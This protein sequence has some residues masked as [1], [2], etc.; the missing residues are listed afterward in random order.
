M[1]IGCAWR[2]E[3]PEVQSPPIQSI[4]IN[5]F[6]GNEK[7]KVDEFKGRQ[8]IKSMRMYEKREKGGYREA[9]NR[10]WGMVH[11]TCFSSTNHETYRFEGIGVADRP[12]KTRIS[13]SI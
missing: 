13:L 3:P 5:E 8:S 9:K 6:K 4:N 12:M 7:H 2:T 1:S 11:S 10:I